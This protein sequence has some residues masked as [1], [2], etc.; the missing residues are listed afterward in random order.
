MGAEAGADAA[1]ADLLLVDGIGGDAFFLDELLDLLT[2]KL[3]ARCLR[4]A[5]R[6]RF[7]LIR[8]PMSSSPG[9]KRKDE[10]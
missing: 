4:Y 3:L 2:E 7:Q 1:L 5:V 6:R 9:Q 10:R 8:Y